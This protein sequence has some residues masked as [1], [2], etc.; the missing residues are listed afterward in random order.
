[1]CIIGNNVQAIDTSVQVAYKHV[2]LNKGCHKVCKRKK[3]PSKSFIWGKIVSHLFTLSRD[4]SRYIAPFRTLRW[5]REAIVCQASDKPQLTFWM[6]LPMF[7]SI[8]ADLWDVFQS[9]WPFLHMRLLPSNCRSFDCFRTSSYKRVYLLQGPNQNPSLTSDTMLYT[10]SSSAIQNSVFSM[11]LGCKEEQF[12]F[13]WVRNSD[14]PCSVYSDVLPTVVR[15]RRVHL[16]FWNC[17]PK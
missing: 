13:P 1:M 12:H 17:E 3:K 5:R 10:K 9:C 8:R 11:E 7:L 4:N 15:P 14:L 6:R 16:S 2:I